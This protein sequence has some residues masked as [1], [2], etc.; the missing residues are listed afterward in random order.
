[1]DIYAD[2]LD[3]LPSVFAVG[4]EYQ[5]FVPF[6]KPAVVWAKVGGNTYYD[7]S[8]G[9]LRS[10]CHVHRVHVPMHILDA[11]KEYTLIFRVMIDRKPYFPES[12]EERSLTI[13][14][15]PLKDGKIN[16][17]L[18]SDAHNMEKEPIAAG[19]YFGEDLDLLVLNG[20]IPNHSGSVEN[21]NSVYR[22]AAGITSGS[23]PVV[24]ARG[25]HDT[26]GIHAEEFGL[27]TPTCNGKTYYTFRLGSLWGMI[28]DCGEDK[29]DT[30]AEYGHTICFH[31][32]RLTETDFIRSV[33]A[34]ADNEYDADGVTKRFVICHIP[35]TNIAKPPFDIEQEL[36]GE[37]ARLLRE[38]VKPQL[39]LF[40]H[41]HSARLCPV[42]DAWDHQGQPCP[43]VVAGWPLRADDDDEKDRYCGA[44]IE[45]TDANARVI[46]NTSENE[47][48]SEH[49]FSF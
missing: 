2:I 5:I 46:F 7:D 22:I 43:A 37:W 1:M 48:L 19:K 49:S 41:K 32:F 44:A 39:L 26:R 35:F 15:R 12:E 13:P 23:C 45:M 20:D 47:I 3:C 25:N 34:N 14:F 40:G 21:F 27:Y 29:P 38:Y 24:F 42:G 18:L 9:I 16:V 4:N 10:N 31:H 11:A 8:N 28:L 30:N 6:K 36:Y 33:I 17:Y